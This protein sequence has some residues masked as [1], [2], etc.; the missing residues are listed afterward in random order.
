MPRENRNAHAFL[1]Q[2]S[3]ANITVSLQQHLILINWITYLQISQG[4]MLQPFK[5]CQNHLVF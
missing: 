2:S 4:K 3:S 5:N 1:L